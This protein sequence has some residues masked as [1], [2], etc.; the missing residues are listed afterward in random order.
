MNF[1]P[2]TYHRSI[3]DL[4]VVVIKVARISRLTNAALPIGAY[5]QKLLST[6]M[7]HRLINSRQPADTLR[8]FPLSLDHKVAITTDSQKIRA[9]ADA[10]MDC[11]QKITNT[12]LP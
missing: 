11:V 5:G 12:R 7:K 9:V 3:C 8:H 6:T 4:R 2:F 10:T 1:N